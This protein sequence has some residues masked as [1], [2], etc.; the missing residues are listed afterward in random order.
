M[1]LIKFRWKRLPSG[2]PGTG[3]NLVVKAHNRCDSRDYKRMTRVSILRWNL[4]E[5]GGKHSTL[6]TAISYEI[7]AVGRVYKTK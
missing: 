4:K 3:D 6:Q 7:N 2:I 1:S 5:V